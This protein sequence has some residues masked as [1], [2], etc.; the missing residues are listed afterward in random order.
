MELLSLLNLSTYQVFDA[1]VLTRSNN[2]HRD[3]RF[4]VLQF[5]FV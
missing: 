5:L 3:R 1:R 4:D 2:V